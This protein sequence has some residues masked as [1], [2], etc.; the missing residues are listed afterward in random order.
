MV[1]QQREAF[2]WHSR[3]RLLHRDHQIIE[4]VQH[5]AQLLR[6]C[7]F[8]TGVRVSDGVVFGPNAFAHQLDDAQVDSGQ[9]AQET[10]A[11]RRVRWRSEQFGHDSL[12]RLAGRSIAGYRSRRQP[13]L[14]IEGRVHLPICG[15]VRIL[16]RGH[17]FG[18]GMVVVDQ[19]TE[20]VRCDSH[21]RLPEHGA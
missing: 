7:R 21:L 19:Q 5:V 17:P 16:Q 15:I 11:R 3:I 18:G 10:E 20:P 9:Q 2:T 1:D 13:L 14:L 8:R 6:T 12:D 4:V